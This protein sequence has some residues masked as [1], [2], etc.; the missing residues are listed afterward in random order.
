M[1]ETVLFNVVLVLWL[2]LAAVTFCALFFITAPYGRFTREGWGPKINRIWGWIVMEMPSPLLMIVFFILGGRFSDPVPIVFLL[3]WEGHYIY[4][5]FLFPFRM[6][7]DRRHMTLLTVLLGVLFN[8]GNGY[9]NG[10]WLFVL[11]PDY[12]L[13]WFK[14]PRFIAG[15]LLFLT[16]L[17]IHVHSDNILRSLRAPGESGYKVPQ[18]GLFTHVSS[19]NYFG[20]ILE[21]AGWAIA[22]WS[23]AG[24][25][26]F[27]W[28]AANL[29]PRA[30]SNHR[31][32][33]S[34]FPDYP[35]ER[36]A[37][38]PFVL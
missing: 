30:W 27:I 6:R 12:T 28:T 5:T 10:A 35:M 13:G 17:A 14:D 36:K 15:I 9:L 26:F 29:V 25:V 2:V 7:G 24:L 3:L 11:S 23:P 38:I 4:R 32:Y 8:L 1:R 19:A 22:T 34:H 21:W 37:L 20:E 16:G 18:G 31:W 33:R